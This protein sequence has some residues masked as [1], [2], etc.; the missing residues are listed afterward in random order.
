MRKKLIPNVEWGMRRAFSELAAVRGRKLK[1]H[2]EDVMETEDFP[3][4]LRFS[5]SEGQERYYATSDMFLSAM[6]QFFGF[7]KEFL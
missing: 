5:I 4:F 7:W 1:L 6:T 3:N 2:N